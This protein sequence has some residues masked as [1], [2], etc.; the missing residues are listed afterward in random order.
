MAR[1]IE[2]GVLLLIL[3]GMDGLNYSAT[4]MKTHRGVAAPWSTDR[5]RLRE[6]KRA[7][8]C[9]EAAETQAAPGEQG[10]GEIS[11]FGRKEKMRKDDYYTT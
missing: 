11:S 4:A 10:E 9:S 5:A 8:S 3:G 6:K 7:S 1:A 2:A